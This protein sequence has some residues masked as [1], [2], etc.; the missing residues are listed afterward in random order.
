MEIKATEENLTNL[1]VDA[2]IVGVFKNGELS[3]N[4]PSDQNFEKYRDICGHNGKEGENKI[5]YQVQK[6]SRFKVALIGL[7]SKVDFTSE[8]ARIAAATGC[9]LLRDENAKSIAIGS[10]G[11]PQASAEGCIL[12]LYRFTELK[13]KEEQEKATI[14]LLQFSGTE[15][16]IMAWNKGVIIANAQNFARKLAEMPA[17]F[18]TPTYFI[19]QIASFFESFEN[20]E[21][22]VYD[23]IWAKKQKMGAFLSVAQGSNQPAKFAVIHYNGGQPDSSPLIFIGKG[24]TF[25]TGGISLKPSQNMGLMRGDCTGAAVIISVLF[26]I[27]KLNLPINVVGIAPLTENM[28]GGKATKPSDVVFASNNK[29]IEVDNTDAEGRLI[30]SDA[31]VYAEKTFKPHTVIDVAT[32]TGA[33]SIALGEH[34]IGTFSRCNT[35]WE[36]LKAAGELAGEEF[37][38][39]PLDSKYSKQLK[40]QIA[41]IKNV[42][43]RSGGAI[44]ATMFLSEFIKLKRWAHLDIAGSTWS[45]K[46]NGYKPKG[47]IGVSVRALIQFSKTIAEKDS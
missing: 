25:D 23:E 46:E 8:K 43:G 7:G 15:K 37:W 31:L 29:S 39:M 34:Y 42:G 47:N 16:E 18:A 2:I 36:E 24:I 1:S 32:L 45:S 22:S 26:G 4:F 11:F 44:T 9:K 20:V 12:G 40:S 33:I 30:L 10:F 5:L 17:N 21:I 13:N 3:Y 38:R 6:P 19:D 14:E 28:P 41:D 27:V 35:L